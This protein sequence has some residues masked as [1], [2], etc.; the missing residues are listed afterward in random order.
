[1]NTLAETLLFIT[2]FIAVGISGL[3]LYNIMEKGQRY[4]LKTAFILFAAFWLNYAL[5]LITLLSNIAD[6]TAIFYNML[7]V[8]MNFLTIPNVLFL[9]IELFYILMQIGED[10]SRKAYSAK[11]YYSKLDQKL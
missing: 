1:M 11:D 10:N 6:S 8:F 7:L 2:P 4:T 3:K 5:F 9:M